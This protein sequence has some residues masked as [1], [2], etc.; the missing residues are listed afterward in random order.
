[1]IKDID[2]LP[3]VV[4]FAA[5]ILLVVATWETAHH[6]VAKECDRLGAFY[7]GQTVYTCQRRPA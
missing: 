1:M 4:L 2:W 6:T 5:L 7:V 3:P